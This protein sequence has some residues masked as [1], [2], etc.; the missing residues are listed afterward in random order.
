MKPG[1]FIYHRYCTVMNLPGPAILPSSSSDPA[2]QRLNRQSVLQVR[3]PSL[4][5]QTIITSHL[6]YGSPYR[7]DPPKT[8]CHRRTVGPLCRSTMWQLADRMSGNNYLKPALFFFFFNRP[9]R[10][11]SLRREPGLAACGRHAASLVLMRLATSATTPAGE[12]GKSE[13]EEKKKKK[14]S[15]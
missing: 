5:C 6:W 4:R 10:C 2:Q 15:N 7:K 14:V 12:G 8:S 13:K 1:R 3:Q 11:S 9:V